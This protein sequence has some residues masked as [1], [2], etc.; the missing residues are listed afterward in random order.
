ME[1]EVSEAKGQRARTTR[2][3]CFPKI[4]AKKCAGQRC[5]KKTTVPMEA[6]LTVE[7]FPIAP[8]AESQ[9]FKTTH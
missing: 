3:R 1:I 7:I 8:F 2:A 9:P 5:D 6:I 4:C